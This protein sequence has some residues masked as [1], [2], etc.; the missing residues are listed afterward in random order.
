MATGN[1]SA[2]RSQFRQAARVACL[3]G[4]LSLA[5]GL[6]ACTTLPQREPAQTA[7]A[8]NLD[9][10]RRC[11]DTGDWQCAQLAFSRLLRD[12]V[13]N[14]YLQFLHGMARDQL[15]RRDPGQTDYAAVAYDSAQQLAPGNYWASL[16]DGYLEL[17]RGNPEEAMNR[18]AL[19]ARDEDAG[20]EAY[21]GLGTA[22]YFAGDL[23]LAS[24]AAQKALEQ[25]PQGEATLRL[26]AIVGA[27]SG[28]PESRGL[29]L[30]HAALAPADAGH[31]QRR[32]EHLLR[33]ASND[34]APADTTAAA[35]PA[36]AP[37]APPAQITVDVCIILSSVLK[38][39]RRGVNLM[40]A[41]RLQYSYEHN[42][43]RSRTESSGS[44]PQ[45]QVT[46]TITQRIG[47]PQ[48]NYS[49]NLFNDS[50]QHYSVLAR[51]S[52]TAHLQR[53]SSF[54]A[55]RTVNVSVSGINLG[56]LQ[57]ID[58]GVTL[59]VTPEQIGANDTT[60]SIRAERSFLS[61]E[62]IGRFNQSL[63]TFKQTV[64]ATAQLEFGQTLILSALAESV[65][66]SSSSQIPLLGSIPIINTF[67]R[68]R[69]SVNREEA[70]LI[71]LTPQRATPVLLPEARPRSAAVQRLLGYWSDTAGPN[72]NL[73][74]ILDRLKRM[75]LFR[76]AEPA[77][78]RTRL[79]DEPALARRALR[80]VSALVEP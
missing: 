54:F 41:L 2:S 12:D 62:E 48:L 35:P 55:G 79:P 21:Y 7:I 68:Q 52:L 16:F 28:D 70:L 53:E 43:N 47:V 10:A 49:L 1:P 18:F 75:R 22:A 20:W 37:A 65:R 51:P 32:V 26:S 30:R 74:L 19:A 46:R 60:V 57:P 38:T 42:S 44:D 59:K 27:A 69:T 66:D 78:L 3:A 58:V 24:L 36:E 72:S 17:R 23:G 76:N 11:A 77:D 9:A 64:N 40:D 34:T 29:A 8:V 63:T 31:L 4:A 71:L 50:G 5:A 80:E 6:A 45:S 67:T 61:Q 25:A 73:D 15:S 39:E 14:G 13:R 33:L 56:A